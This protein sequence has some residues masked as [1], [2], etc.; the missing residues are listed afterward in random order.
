M[1]PS[2]VLTTQGSPFFSS[3]LTLLR[4]NWRAKQPVLRDGKA[5]LAMAVM[6]YPK[7]PKSQEAWRGAESRGRLPLC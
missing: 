2:S 7:T 1:N 5:Y 4:L 6:K 3:H